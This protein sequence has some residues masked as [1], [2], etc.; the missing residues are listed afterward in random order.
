LL[1]F[2]HSKKGFGYNE[3]YLTQPEGSLVKVL[4]GH[5]LN[6]FPTMR[7]RLMA[8]LKGADG[9]S[10]ILLATEGKPRADGEP[11]Q[12][13]MFRL[14]HKG[15]LGFW[16]R[17]VPG[18]WVRHTY[19]NCLQ[20][21]DIN[22]D[23]LDDILMCNGHGKPAFI[24]LQGADSS[25]SR[26]DIRMYGWMARDWSNARVADVTG[27]GVPDLIVVGTVP[28]SVVSY[29]RIFKGSSQEPYLKLN[30]GSLV[31][32]KILDYRAPDLE[33]LD[34]N[35]DGVA[36]IYVVQ[37]DNSYGKYC[38]RSWDKPWN[39]PQPDADYIPPVDEAPDLLLV[40][41]APVLGFTEVVM[42]HAEPGC[43]T[44]VE[45]FGNNR[46]MIL[47]QGDFDQVGHNLLLQW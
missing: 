1:C 34:I 11:N 32:E 18:P 3:V 17:H 44:L 25:W 23:G 8:K 19:A 12:H 16:F 38:S 2:R 10:L 14:E 9:S 33:V 4:Q 40:G 28:D 7:N 47:A 5:N 36:D 45:L 13:R 31:Y 21:V 46:T 26:L 6:K 35:S 15:P 37:Y 42:D 22:Q 39:G 20:I 29:I 24:F 43:G 41:S 27:D 30:A